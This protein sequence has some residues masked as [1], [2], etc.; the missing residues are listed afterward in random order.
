MTPADFS[1][2]IPTLN[3]AT[4]ITAAIESA[5][6]AGAGEVILS[7]GGSEDETLQLAKQAGVSKIVRSIPGRGIQLN[8]G[9]FVA[10]SDFLLFLHADNRLPPD[11]LQQ[12]CEYPDCTWGA[13][14]QRIDSNRRI[15]RFIE[16]GNDLRVKYQARPFGDQAIFVRRSVFKEIGGFAEIPLMEDVEIAARLRKVSWPLLLPGP[17][18]ISARRWESKGVIRQTFLNWWLQ[19]QFACGV[20]PEKLRKQ[21]S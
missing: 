20:S 19:V 18:T 1:V 13:F 4:E 11:C 3:E 16:F 14:R 17:I 12:I 8:S 5:F 15:F 10:Q 21:Y 9:A 7:D 6:A 2:V